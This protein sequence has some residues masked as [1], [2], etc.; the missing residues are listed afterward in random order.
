MGLWRGATT[1]HTLHG[2]AREEQPSH[3]PISAQ[4]FGRHV[5]L[6][7]AWWLVPHRCL[8]I[9][10]SLAPRL[11][12]KSMAANVEL[13]KGLYTS[14]VTIYFRYMRCAALGLGQ[15]A[16]SEHTLHGSGSDEQP[17]P[18]PN[19]AQPGGRPFFFGQTSLLAPCRSLRI[20]ASLAPRLAEKSLAAHGSKINFHNTRLFSW[21]RRFAASD[22][23][24]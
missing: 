18:R 21:P 15:G 16:R 13:F 7:Q 1:A 10:S 9:C 19:A 11:A 17:G 22:S 4:P 8:R 12:Q 6:S 20:G 5:F 24:L 14:V 23:R 2:S 3:R